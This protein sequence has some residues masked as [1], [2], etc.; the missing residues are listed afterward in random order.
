MINFI[1]KR[2][3]ISMIKKKKRQKEIALQ[4]VMELWREA[5]KIASENP[6]RARHYIKQIR[7]IKRHVKIDLPVEIRRGYCKKC[8]LP[9]V[10]GKT[11]IK[12]V[13]KGVIIIVCLAC[14]NKRRF[15]IK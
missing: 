6:E 9:L 11:A 10:Y 5:I 13:R 3:N 14:G 8:Y 7:A 12:R 15:V 1:K 4:N 2:K